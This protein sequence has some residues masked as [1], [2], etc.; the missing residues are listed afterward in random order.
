MNQDLGNLQEIHRLG[1]EALYEKLGSYGMLKF[2]EIY[3]S[4]AG[5]YSKERH[6]LLK[7]KSV[8]ELADN[9]VK[10]RKKR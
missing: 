6:N 2:L 4:G 3:D 9:I 1:L 10:S 5:D 7:E 8:T